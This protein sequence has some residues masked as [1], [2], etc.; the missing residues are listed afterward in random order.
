M[1]R[2]SFATFFVHLFSLDL[3]CG[4]FQSVHLS[5]EL[6]PTSAG[7]TNHIASADSFDVRRDAYSS[8]SNG[9]SSNISNM[10]TPSDETSSLNRN[11]TGSVLMRRNASYGQMRSATEANVLV[12]YT[13]GTIGMMRNKN[14]GSFKFEFSHFL[15]LFLIHCSLIMS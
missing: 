10:L 14:N 5:R 15:F 6:M 7:N 9:R 4:C 12:I 3:C 13:G 11:D 2:A 1:F 8:E